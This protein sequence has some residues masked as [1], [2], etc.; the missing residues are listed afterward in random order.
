MGTASEKDQDFKFAATGRGFV[1]Q[2]RQDAMRRAA[3]CGPASLRPSPSGAH[4][5]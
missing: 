1:K 5:V 3:I 4:F 2:P